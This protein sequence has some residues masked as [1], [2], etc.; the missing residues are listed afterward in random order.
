MRP[1]QPLP[2]AVEL[3]AQVRSGERRAVDALDDCLARVAERDPSLGAFVHLDEAGA[4]AAAE[5]VDA[6]VASGADPGPFA[7][8][9]LG[10]KDLEDARGMPTSMGSRLYLGRTASSDSL[11][12]ARLRAAGAVPVGKTAAPELGALNH[13][14]SDAWGTTRNPWD[15]RRT[16]G[17]SSGGSAAAVSAGMVA[18]ATASDGGGSTRSPAAFCGLVGLKPSFGRIP[19]LGPDVAELAADGVLATSVRDVARHLDVVAGPD[20]RCRTSLPRAGICYESV[21]DDLA[22][23]GVRA[24]WSSDLGISDCDPEVASI[25]GAAALR[26]SVA[27]DLVL[28]EEPIRLTAVVGAYLSTTRL[29]GWVAIDE[30][31]WPACA[32]RLERHTVERLRDT[33]ALPLPR[34]VRGAKRRARVVEELAAVMRDVELVLCPTTALAAFEADDPTSATELAATPYTFLAN[35]TGVPAVSV[36]AGVTASGLP[37]GLQIIGRQHADHVVLRAARLW[38][39]T[40]PWPR[41]APG[42]GSSHPPPPGRVAPR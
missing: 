8:V 42:W 25:A 38:E 16:P 4:R 10:V 28:D 41:H 24:R 17:G 31:E 19:R 34:W 6:I 9:P 13:T 23:S 2:D 22:I 21:I 3:A 32:E 39:L 7:G 27:A 30:D 33:A 5:R 11:H 35:L 14:R 15:T 37:V 29:D 36:P 26:L 20:P 18:L 40:R 12:V 1:V